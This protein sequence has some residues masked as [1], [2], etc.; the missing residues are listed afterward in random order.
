VKTILRLLPIAASLTIAIV[1][2]S[3]V[4]AAALSDADLLGNW[5]GRES[6]YS[7]SR[8]VMIV[9]RPSDSERL[10][11]DII[12]FEPREGRIAVSWQR[13]DGK[14]VRTEFAEFS[15]DGKQMVQL[16]NSGGPRRE[17]RRC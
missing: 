16:S 6:N 14:V 11:F 4:P 1:F 5:C 10:V 7:F 2:A 9:T 12:A 8:K 3:T 17:F 15:T 13:A